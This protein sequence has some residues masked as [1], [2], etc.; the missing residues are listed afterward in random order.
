MGGRVLGSEGYTQAAEKAVNFIFTKLVKADGRL[1]ARYRDGEAAISG[2]VDD[3]TFT[4]WGLIEL[5]ETTYNPVYLQRAL[6]LNDDLL[7]LFWDNEKGGLF[8]YGCDS[9][10]LITRPKEIYDGA[11][12]SCNSVAT[13]NFLRLARLT[14]RNELEE[15]AAEQFKTFGGSLEQ[16]PSGHSFMLT[17][18][19]FNMATTKEVVVVEGTEQPG[20]EEMLNLLKEDFKPFT[21]SL[22]SSER[23]KDLKEVVPF[24]SNY[25]SVNGKS[26]AYV[27]VNFSC[28]APII[29]PGELKEVLS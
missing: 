28:Q 26:T 10:Q 7:K 25:K 11:T 17:A 9:E 27:C 6:R 2:Y 24:I 15:K 1:L 18:L 3:Y 21:L 22:Y 19:L 4:I 14:G 8:I 13:L 29:S 16:V 5:Y 12:P 23:Y 20:S